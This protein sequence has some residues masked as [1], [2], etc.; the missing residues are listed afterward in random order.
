MISVTRLDG[1][2]MLLNADLV[3]WIERTPDTVI[4][5]VNGDRFL[6]RETPEEIVR[7]VI[8]FKRAVQAGPVLRMADGS[9]G[10]DG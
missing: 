9:A 6:V 1:S 10:S 5:L 4:G 3:E 8:D 7:R 2:P